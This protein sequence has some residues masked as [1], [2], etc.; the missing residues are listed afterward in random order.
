[1]SYSP[2]SSFEFGSSY[3]TQKYDSD[4]DLG[5]DFFGLDISGRHKGW[6]L[7][8]EYVD[9]S[10]ER[11]GQADLEQDGYCDDMDECSLGRHSCHTT[12]V[13]ENT[14]GG[15]ECTCV[16]GYGISSEGICRDRDECAENVCD[17]LATCTNSEGGFACALTVG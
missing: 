5:I 11:L 15:H 3:H 4:G 10:V 17:P 1:M 13:C 14:T 7:R 16:A 8:A 9:A 12:A 6:E 2:T